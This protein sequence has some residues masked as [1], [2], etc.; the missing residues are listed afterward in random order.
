MPLKVVPYIKGGRGGRLAELPKLSRQALVLFSP[1]VVYAH[2]YVQKLLGHRRIESTM[3]YTRLVEFE[4]SEY[5]SRGTSSLQGARRLVE[6]GF[7][8]VCDHDG[9][10]LFRKRR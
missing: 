3:L 7:E 10:K 1:F 2:A 6:A 4:S 9:Y 5:T 8:Y